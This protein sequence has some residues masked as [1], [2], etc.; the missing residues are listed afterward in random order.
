MKLTRCDRGHYYDVEKFGKC[1]QC[2][3]ADDIPTLPEKEIVKPDYAQTVKEI[4]NDPP[5]KKHN[6]PKS[7]KAPVVGWLVCVEGEHKG[8]DFRLK[9]GGNFIG[10]SETMDVCIRK[11]EAVSRNKHLNVTFDPKSGIFWVTPGDTKELAYLN[12]D[13]VLERK[14]IKAYDVIALGESKLLFVPFCS[15]SFSWEENK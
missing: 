6:V 9:S 5:T 10:R 14:E 7:G 4:D 11:D 8:E 1:P 2:G 15:D 12:D 13:I 3:S